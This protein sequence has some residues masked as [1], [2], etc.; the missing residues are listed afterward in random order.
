MSGNSNV[1]NSGIY[2]AGDQR[3]APASESNNAERF[4]EGQPNSH[5]ST[6]SSTLLPSLSHQFP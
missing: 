4:N 6:D 3:N 1:G 2:E 5:I